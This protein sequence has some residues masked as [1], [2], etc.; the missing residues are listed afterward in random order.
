MIILSHSLGLQDKW[1]KSQVLRPQKCKFC[2][3]KNMNC[4]L[5]LQFSDRLRTI[6]LN[7]HF[8]VPKTMYMKYCQPQDFNMEAM[9]NKK[10]VKRDI[11][12]RYR[13]RIYIL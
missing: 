4:R 1:F 3:L 9:K 7:I 10:N 13:G 11:N 8:Y 5:T 2:T 12:H 6:K